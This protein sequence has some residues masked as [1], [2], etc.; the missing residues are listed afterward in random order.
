MDG[1]ILKTPHG[2]STY[3]RGLRVDEGAVPFR[4][5]EILSYKF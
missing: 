3:M 5:P 1:F 2:S 4:G